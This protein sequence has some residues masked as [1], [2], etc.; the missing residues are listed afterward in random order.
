MLN[1][2]RF[3]WLILQADISYI[4]AIGAAADLVSRVFLAISSAFFSVKARYVYLAGALFTIIA[5]F[6]FL[7]VSDFAGMAIITAILGFLRTWIHVTLPLVF[8]EYLSQERFASGYGLFMFL[9][10]N[11]MFIIGPIIGYLRDVTGS[12]VTAF[13]ALSVIMAFCVVPWLFEILYKKK[14]KKSLQ[15]TENV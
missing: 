5:R 10:G 13:H 11:I 9:Q 12:Y 15:A 7:C 2:K 4:I 6:A 8:A 14:N 3:F 1:D